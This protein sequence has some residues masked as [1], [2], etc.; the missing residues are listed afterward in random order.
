MSDQQ[1]STQITTQTSSSKA[2]KLQ[3]DV[4]HPIIYNKIIQELDLYADSSPYT[5]YSYSSN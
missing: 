1:V 5:S 3:I 4:L 2:R